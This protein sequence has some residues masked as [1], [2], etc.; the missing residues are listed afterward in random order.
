MEAFFDSWLTHL[1]RLRTELLHGVTHRP[2]LIPHAV[3]AFLIHYRDYRGAKARLADSDLLRAVTH[4]WLTPFERTF[5]WIG[6]WKP[7]LA[8]RLLPGRCL[9]APDQRTAVEM[10]RREVELAE[11]RISEDMAGAQEAMAGHAVLVAMRARLLYANGNAWEAAVDEVSGALRAVVNAAEELRD[12]TLRRLV[13]ILTAAQ[14]AE[15]LAAAVELRLR[16]RR[17]GL[18]RNE[19]QFA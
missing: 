16:V 5:L 7:S 10:F 13:E 19:R 2:D 4:P 9:L 18:R 17:W 6:G 8:F 11:H 1:D 3:D 14:T 15:F 12:A